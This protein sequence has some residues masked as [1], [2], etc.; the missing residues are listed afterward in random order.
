MSYGNLR[1]SVVVPTFRRPEDLRRC[2][3]GLAAQLRP[4]DEVVVVRR[5]DDGATALVLG[6][7]SDQ[8]REVL[9]EEPGLVAAMRA[10]MSAATGDVLALTDDDAVPRPDWVARIA[11]HFTDP[12]LGVLGGRDALDGDRAVEALVVGEPHRPEAP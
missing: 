10:G 9:V 7:N 8:V 3:R 5:G 6:E 11:A 12:D 2:L 4:A 1:V